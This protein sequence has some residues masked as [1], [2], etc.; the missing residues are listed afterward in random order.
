MLRNCVA[1]LL[2]GRMTLGIRFN[3]A[4]LI[5][6][7]RMQTKIIFIGCAGIVQ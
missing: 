7:A 3:S 2:R 4:E 5:G 1:A 6:M